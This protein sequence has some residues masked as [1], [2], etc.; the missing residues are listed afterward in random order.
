[1]SRTLFALVAAG[2]LSACAL[3]E[4]SANTA[5]TP[6]VEKETI[7]GTRIPSKSTSQS[8]KRQEVDPLTRDEI[9]RPKSNP[10]M[11]GG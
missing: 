3:P 8:V 4:P 2:L 5:A 1:M 10:M 6:Y 7:T 11:G 9:F